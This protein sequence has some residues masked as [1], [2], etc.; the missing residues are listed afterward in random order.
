MEI[1]GKECP[2]ANLAKEF[3]DPT[4]RNCKVALGFLDATYLYTARSSN[5]MM[6]KLNFVNSI[7]HHLKFCNIERYMFKIFKV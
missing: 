3:R 4:G 2:W 7:A 6:Q 5:L 1:L